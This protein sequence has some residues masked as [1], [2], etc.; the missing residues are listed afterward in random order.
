MAVLC[1]LSNLHT[2]ERTCLHNSCSECMHMQTVYFVHWK[3][4]FVT[5]RFTPIPWCVALVGFR[6]G[7][8]LQVGLVV[9]RVLEPLSVLT[10]SGK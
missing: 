9:V 3:A 6:D 1:Y 8:F 10:L 4:F 2:I 7:C 5:L